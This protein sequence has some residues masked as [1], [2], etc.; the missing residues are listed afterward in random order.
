LAAK[1]QS[2]TQAA[3]VVSVLRDPQKSIPI[4][5]QQWLTQKERYNSS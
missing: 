2:T 1:N 5:G 4:A 3:A